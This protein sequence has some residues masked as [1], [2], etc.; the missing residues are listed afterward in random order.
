MRSLMLLGLVGLLGCAADG[1]PC[2]ERPGDQPAFTCP[3]G[4]VA[5]CP[6]GECTYEPVLSWKATAMA[7][8]EDGA[9]VCTN[10][11]PVVC[12]DPINDECR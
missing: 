9:G 7:T 10:G 2:M 5:Y 4:E 3:D 11:Q 1:A 6:G 8:C 12:G